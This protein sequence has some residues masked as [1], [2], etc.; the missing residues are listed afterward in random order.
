VNLGAARRGSDVPLADAILERALSCI[1]DGEV[2]GIDKDGLPSFSGLTD[3]LSG[4]STAGLVYYVFDILFG[5]D[6]DLTR[7]PLTTRKAILKTVL[8][9]LAKKQRERVRYVDHHA[10]DGLALYQAACEMKLEGIVS[11]VKDAA[12]KPDDRSGIWTK[13][14][15]R[16]RC[17]SL[18]S[19]AGKPMARA[20]GRCCSAPIAVDASN[21]SAPLVPAS[22]SITCPRCR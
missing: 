16:G 11:K 10:G 9:K 6:E 8:R 1:L 3:A 19:A 17:R 22:I 18:L 21:M 15:C 2:C 13:A 4:K 7:H 5:N 12:Y 20:S 14:K